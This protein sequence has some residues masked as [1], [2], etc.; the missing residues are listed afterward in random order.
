MGKKKG[1][2]NGR[3]FKNL[4][5]LKIKQSSKGQTQVGELSC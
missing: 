3:P 2:A 1:P 5:N 4:L